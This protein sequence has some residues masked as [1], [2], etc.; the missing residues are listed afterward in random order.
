M[1]EA[2]ESGFESIAMERSQA[3]TQDALAPPFSTAIR[4]KRLKSLSEIQ[5]Q[6]DGKARRRTIS[7]GNFHLWTNGPGRF[8]VRKPFDAAGLICSVGVGSAVPRTHRGCSGL[9]VLA[10]ANFTRRSIHCNFQTG[11]HG[12]RGRRQRGDGQKRCRRSPAARTR[13][14]TP[15]VRSL[16]LRAQLQMAMRPTK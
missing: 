3:I 2:G 6:L 7:L 5:K 8:L 12:V 14:E 4:P 13:R 10:I 9:A 16:A 15:A 11:S 1:G